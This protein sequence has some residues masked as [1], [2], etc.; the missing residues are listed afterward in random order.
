MFPNWIIAAHFRTVALRLSFTLQY[1]LSQEKYFTS[2]LLKRNQYFAT[3][4]LFFIF[5]ISRE[6]VVRTKNS[7]PFILAKT[8]ENIRKGKYRDEQVAGFLIFM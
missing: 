5:P 3:G 8:I 7:N 2:L 6:C 1:M 4:L